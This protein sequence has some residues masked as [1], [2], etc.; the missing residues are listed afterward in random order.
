MVT[1]PS[2]GEDNDATNNYCSACGYDL[3]ADDLNSQ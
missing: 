1:C 2:C 3:A